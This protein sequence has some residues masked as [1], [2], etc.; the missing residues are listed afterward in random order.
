MAR[1]APNPHRLKPRPKPVTIA[2]LVRNETGEEQ[3]HHRTIDKHFKSLPKKTQAILRERAAGQT[4]EEIAKKR[5]TLR[6]SIG[7]VYMRAMQR[8][9]L[10]IAGAPRYWKTGRAR[11][12]EPTPAEITEAL[13]LSRNEIGDAEPLRQYDARRQ[14]AKAGKAAAEEGPQAS[15]SRQEGRLQPELRK[16]LQAAGLR[17]SARPKRPAPG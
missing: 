1:Q 16:K 12:D 6:G 8:I 3:A 17:H 10:A 9:K 14:A 15:E 5:S 11:A 13:E 2:D 7:G 4:F